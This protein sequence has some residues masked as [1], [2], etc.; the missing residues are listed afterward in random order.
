MS[1]SLTKVPTFALNTLLGKINVNGGLAV[2]LTN[3]T[4]SS[5][6]AKLADLTEI[7]YTYCSSRVPTVTSIAQVGGL[8]TLILAQLLLTTTGALGPFRY[9]YLYETSTADKN[10]IGV[11][12]YGYSITLYYS[13]DQFNIAF[14]TTNGVLTIQ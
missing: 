1:F 6:F 12:D 2:A 14:D 7:S 13:G 11:Y 3:T 5:T 4:H 9:L 10:L 8:A